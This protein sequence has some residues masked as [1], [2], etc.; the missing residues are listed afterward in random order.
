MKDMYL[1][2][3]RLNLVERKTKEQ[4]AAAA[5]ASGRSKKKKWGKGKNKEK[6]NHAVFID[7]A[8]QSKI[9]ESKN[10]KV[11]TP[12]TISEKYKVNLSVAR[13]VIKYL[14][15]QNLIKEVCMQSHTQKL[16]TKV[17]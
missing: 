8:L 16:Y 11:I 3:E 2:G 6:L 9:L 5:A 12:S 4:I 15:E 13:S 7:K 1:L 10:M 17:A 14:A